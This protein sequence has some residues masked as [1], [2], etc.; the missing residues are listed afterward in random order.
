VGANV[1]GID[2]TGLY[3]F[4]SV[5]LLMA[6]VKLIGAHDWSWWRVGLPLG[7]YVGFNVAHIGTGFIYLSRADIGQRPPQEEAALL[8]QHHRTPYFWLA[9]VHFALFALGVTELTAPSESLNG[10]WSAFGN[11]GVMTAYGSLAVVNLFLYWS[12]IFGR[13]LSDS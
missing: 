8:R 2:T 13:L 4:A 10:F 1:N 6:L 5:S 9:F 11:V 3:L 12:S 7:M